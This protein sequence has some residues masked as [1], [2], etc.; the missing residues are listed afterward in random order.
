MTHPLPR[1]PSTGRR[2]L[3]GVAVAG[4]MWRVWH[5]SPRTTTG[6]EARRYGPLHRFDPH[7][8]GPPR[9]HDDVLVLYGSPALEVAVLEVFHGGAA[10]VD[11][12]PSWRGTLVDVSGR[13]RLFDLTDAEACEAVGADPRLGD[14]DLDREGYAVTQAWGRFLHASPGIH[15]LRYFSRRATDRGGVCMALFRQLAIGEAQHQHLLRDDALWPY[16]VHTLHAV[17]VAVRAVARC[18]RC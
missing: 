5:P 9:V 15:G 14:A 12:C 8:A 13:T 17:G 10:V 1:A 16:L 11:V 18:P 4:P 7:P 6:V 3:D 2:G